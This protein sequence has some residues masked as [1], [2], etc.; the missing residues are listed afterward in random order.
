MVK[1][2]VLKHGQKTS[3]KDAEVTCWGKLFRH[4]LPQLRRLSR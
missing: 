3:T 1:D 4:K 2:R